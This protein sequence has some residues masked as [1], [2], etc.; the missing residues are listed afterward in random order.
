MLH[1]SSSRNRTLTTI[2][3]GESDSFEDELSTEID[4]DDADIF[5]DD[6]ICSASVRTSA[7]TS[8]TSSR[9][10]S[11]VI[12]SPEHRYDSM[13]QG[14]QNPGKFKYKTLPENIEKGE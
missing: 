9:S 10:P 13:I 12:D 3:L 14:H 11:T 7:T 2:L 5:E 4:Y 6:N 1:F 8:I